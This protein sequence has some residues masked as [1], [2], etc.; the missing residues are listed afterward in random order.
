M[1]LDPSHVAAQ[2]VSGIDLLG[3]GTILLHKD[4][5]RGLTTSAAIWLVA[6][7]GLACGT[8]LVWK[9]SSPPCLRCCGSSR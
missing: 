5:I 9:Q 7:I 4:L 2:I 1:R 3:A 6:G 8:G